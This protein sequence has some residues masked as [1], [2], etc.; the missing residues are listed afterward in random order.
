MSRAVPGQNDKC[1][2]SSAFLPH[3]LAFFPSSA[4][5]PVRRHCPR[6]PRP[7]QELATTPII[8]FSPLRL[9]R[10][11][12]IFSLCDPRP[13]QRPPC[14]VCVQ[15]WVECHSHSWVGGFL[16]ARAPARPIEECVAQT[17]ERKR[18]MGWIKIKWSKQRSIDAKDW[19]SKSLT[20]PW[21]VL[22]R[23]VCPQNAF[24]FTIPVL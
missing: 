24:I 1:T 5:L 18:I 11:F 4:S 20:A 7:G 17:E 13:P 21:K 15:M 2:L 6:V 10:F 16:T 9:R 22:V 14:G 23:N 19:M 12:F 3:S 8:P